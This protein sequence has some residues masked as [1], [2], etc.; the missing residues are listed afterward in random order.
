MIK[1]CIFFNLIFLFAIKLT[2]Q[3]N[4][5]VIFPVEPEIVTVKLSDEENYSKVTIPET[6]KIGIEGHPSLPVKYIKLL[7]PSNAN[8]TGV[9]INNISVKIFKPDYI[10]EPVQQEISLSIDYVYPDF[11]KPDKTVY[12]LNESYPNR[13]VEINIIN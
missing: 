9:T 12:E 2:G 5:Q 10:I 7:I 8:A 1:K 3:I 4:H 11:V 13:R 6:F